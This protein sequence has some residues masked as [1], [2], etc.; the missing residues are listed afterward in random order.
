[1]V[2]TDT[3]REK[4]GGTYG[5]GTSGSLTIRPKQR[6]S[7]SI[8]FDTDPDKVDELS[9]MVLDELN[10]LAEEGIPEEYFQK[11]KLNFL[12]GIPEMRI[13]NSYWMSMLEMYYRYGLDQDSERESVIEGITPEKVQSFINGLLSQGNR[14]KLIMNPEK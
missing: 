8:Q 9:V 10:K 3:I 5:V 7:M 2:Y 11:A 4:E 1:M 13:S 6:T 12:K 14:I